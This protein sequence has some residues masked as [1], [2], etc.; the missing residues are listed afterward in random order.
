MPD[1]PTSPCRDGVIAS[2]AECLNNIGFSS[3]EAVSSTIADT[4]GF[5]SHEAGSSTLAGSPEPAAESLRPSGC[6]LHPNLP[7]S[8]KQ[9]A[10][11]SPQAT[12]S[13]QTAA[14]PIS[15]NS[16]ERQAASPAAAALTESESLQ[17]PDSDPVATT[18][19]L[20]SVVNA[21]SGLETPE[22][23]LV[24]GDSSLSESDML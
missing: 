7:R 18:Q 21:D 20:S 4:V 13:W 16:N 24:N 22:E 3:L 9:L 8:R 1:P 15:V 12:S 2:T 5:S 6:R 19:S 23:S 17:S 11:G 14:R 10:H